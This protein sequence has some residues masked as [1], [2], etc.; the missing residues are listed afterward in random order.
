MYAAAV[1][2]L[3]CCVCVS[4]YFLMYTFFKC[5]CVNMFVQLHIVCV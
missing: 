3:L 5:L 4:V 1:C 2:V